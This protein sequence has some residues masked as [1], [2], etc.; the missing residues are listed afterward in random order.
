MSR[1]MI[2]GF[3]VAIVTIAG[4]MN[5]H[6]SL[7]ESR[8]LNT[9][10]DDAKASGES[11]I[12][13]GP[14]KFTVEQTIVASGPFSIVGAGPWQT[15]ILPAAGVT[16]F[17]LTSPNR[18]SRKFLSTEPN[19]DHRLGISLSGFH[20]R[21]TQGSGQTGIVFRG[22][23]DEV[24]CENL[25]FENLDQAIVAGVLNEKNVGW[26]RESWLAS[27]IIQNCGTSD[28]PA[29]EIVQHASDVRQD[30]CNHLTLR[31]WAVIYSPGVGLRIADE[32]DSETVRH[33]FISGFMAH[34]GPN[35]ARPSG[36]LISL[37]G[38]L[39]FVQIDGL[40][41]GSWAENYVRVQ[42]IGKAVPRCVSI[43]GQVS[44][45]SLGVDLQDV[46]DCVVNLQQ[47]GGTLTRVSPRCSGVVI[48][49][50]KL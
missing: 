49:G 43:Q 40:R 38:G 36:P 5:F 8:S 6:Q 1:V 17:D 20:I 4:M 26:L 21:G 29:A 47:N 22:G 12:T 31:D 28:L 37:E 7:D 42:A 39:Q 32:S 46:N 24:R 44:S 13:L 45:Q 50:S 34:G 10:V 27:I 9:I 30:G 16:C 35:A 14:G 3:L 18:S 19:D 2:A 48:N 11:V 33:I 15:Q 23:C 41:G 25:R